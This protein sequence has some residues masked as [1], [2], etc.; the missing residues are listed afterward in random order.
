MK[1]TFK[2]FPLPGT[3]TVCFHLLFCTTGSWERRHDTQHNDI[4]NSET[5]HNNKKTQHDDTR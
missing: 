2:S 4:L 1:M 5:Q 3:E